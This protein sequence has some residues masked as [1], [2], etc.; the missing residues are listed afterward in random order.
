MTDKKDTLPLKPAPG[1]C[2]VQPYKEELQGGWAQP[3]S[4]SEKDKQA[5]GL[6][7]AFSPNAYITDYGAVIAPP[8]ELAVGKVII[9]RKYGFEDVTWGSKKYRL[10]RHIDIAAIID[11]KH[12]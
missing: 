10:V 4:E 11:I 9:H 1:Y 5:K 8:K 12:E 6:V 3:E 2:I 7:L